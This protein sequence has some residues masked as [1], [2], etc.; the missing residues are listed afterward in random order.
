MTMIYIIDLNF[1]SLWIKLNLD[2]VLYFYAIKV[3]NLVQTMNIDRLWTI[4]L[5]YV[6]G[7]K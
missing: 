4:I 7:G 3:S 6:F 5:F 2:Y 1:N